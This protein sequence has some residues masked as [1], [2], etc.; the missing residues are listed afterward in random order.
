MRRDPFRHSLLRSHLRTAMTTERG[1]SRLRIVDLASRRA[2]VPSPL[3]PVARTAAVASCRADSRWGRTAEA[4]ERRCSCFGSSASLSR[5][6]LL[7]GTGERRRERCGTTERASRAVERGTVLALAS[8]A[9]PLEL[10]E[11]LP[12]SCRIIPSCVTPCERAVESSLRV[13]EWEEVKRDFPH[14][15][16][17]RL[18]LSRPI[19]QT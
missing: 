9:A 17:F 2:P 3:L 8:S 10:L 16:R 4:T 14:F 15:L 18:S 12:S 11:S 13:Y 6:R 7:P 5:S 1:P 19:S